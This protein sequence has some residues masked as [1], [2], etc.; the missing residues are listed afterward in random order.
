VRFV[1]NFLNRGDLKED[2]DEKWLE[3]LTDSFPKFYLHTLEQ[4]GRGN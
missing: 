2:L 4:I 3:E 1:R